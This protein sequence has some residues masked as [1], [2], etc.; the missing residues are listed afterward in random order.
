[1]RWWY[2]LLG[3]LVLMAFVSVKVGLK[4]YNLLRSAS[5]HVDVT[6]AGKTGSI[7]LTSKNTKGGKWQLKAK[8]ADLKGSIVTLEDVELLYCSERIK[9]CVKVTGEK[10]KIDREKKMGDLFGDVKVMSEDWV[11][12][13]QHLVWYE[14][15]NKA[16]F[17]G[18]FV[19]KGR[20]L[21]F[22]KDACVQLDRELV[23]VEHLKRAVV[24]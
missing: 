6:Q 3:F 24:R 13:S 21:V 17:P 22:G 7:V 12:T 5:V 10:G 19:L 4:Y 23:V 8:K 16:C 9:T 11:I 1:M 14:N 20:Y 18:D 2:W 15:Q